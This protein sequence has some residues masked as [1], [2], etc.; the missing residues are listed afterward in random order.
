MSDINKEKYGNCFYYVE[1]HIFT[2]LKFPD[3]KLWCFFV[4]TNREIIEGDEWCWSEKEAVHE[5]INY[6]DKLSD[7][8]VEPDYD[9][10]VSKEAYGS[11][12]FWESRRKFKE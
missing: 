6:I 1:E 4:E 9:P 12:E 10:Y 2:N 3:V 7:G 8:D 5:A 11:Y